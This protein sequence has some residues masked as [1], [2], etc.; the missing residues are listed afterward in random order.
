MI[1]R[2]TMEFEPKPDDT[3]EVWFSCRVSSAIIQ[4]IEFERE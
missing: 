2:L 1:I 4:A 3:I